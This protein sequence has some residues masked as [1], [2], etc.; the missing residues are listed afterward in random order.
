MI[1]KAT[2]MGEH[3]T[4]HYLRSWRFEKSETACSP[5]GG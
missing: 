1:S 5:I 4:R 3:Y 2:E